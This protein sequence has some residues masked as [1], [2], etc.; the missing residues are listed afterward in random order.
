MKVHIKNYTVIYTHIAHINC[1]LPLLALYSMPARYKAVLL[2]TLFIQLT[3]FNL[4][5]D[6]DKL[7]REPTAGYQ[8]TVHMIVAYQNPSITNMLEI[9]IT[10]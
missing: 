1:N 4:R 8:Y 3:A 7:K 6:K 5:H 2:K 10:S 9:R